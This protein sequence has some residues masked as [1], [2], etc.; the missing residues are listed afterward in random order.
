MIPVNC[1][2]VQDVL[3]LSDLSGTYHSSFQNA[4]LVLFQPMHYGSYNIV[5]V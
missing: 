4:S 2:E 1:D 5:S 3:C